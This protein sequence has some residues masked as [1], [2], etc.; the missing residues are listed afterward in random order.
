TGIDE[1]TKSVGQNK[2]N[3]QISSSYPI[4]TTNDLVYF[5]DIDSSR[6]YRTTLNITDSVVTKFYTWGYAQ[7]LQNEG[8][9]VYWNQESGFSFDGASNAN[10]TEANNDR[11]FAFSNKYGSGQSPLPANGEWKSG[12]TIS[13]NFILAY[14]LPQGVTSVDGSLA[15]YPSGIHPNMQ[16]STKQAIAQALINNVRTQLNEPSLF[17]LDGTPI[18]WDEIESLANGK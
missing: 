10:G 5:L 17:M 11:V 18:T 7:Q 6:T 3:F 13:N 4:E 16:P 9:Q 1:I 12:D 15:E 8:I 14:N 2:V